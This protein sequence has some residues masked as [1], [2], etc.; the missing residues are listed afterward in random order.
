MPTTINISL[1]SELRS[2]IDRNCGDTGLFATPSEFIRA[3]LREKKELQEASAI[4]DGVMEGYRD[5]MAGRT[6]EFKGSL[7]SSLEEARRL[8]Q[9]G[10]PT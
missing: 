8:E 6:I 5:L 4:R 1:T 9:N 2:F 10:W 3:L 7:R